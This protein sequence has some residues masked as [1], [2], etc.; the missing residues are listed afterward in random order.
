[1]SFIGNM[2]DPSKSTGFQAQSAPVMNLTDPSQIAAANAGVG[3]AA[4]SQKA[5]ADAAAGAGG[6]ANQSSVYN[7]QAALGNQLGGLNGAGTEG[8]AT[9]QGQQ[10]GN[11]LLGAGGVQAQTAALGQNAALTGQ[12]GGANGV[13]TQSSAI[14]GLQNLAGQQ[15]GLASQ[16][17]NIANGTG[18][19]PAQAMLNN[20]TGQNVANQAA[21]MASQRGAGSNVGLLARQAGQQGANTQQQAVGQGA[22][23]QA[24]QSLG[25]LSGLAAQQQAIGNTQSQIGGLGTTQVGQ[26]LSAIGQGAGIGAGLTGQ[27]QTQVANNYGMGSNTVGQQMGQQQ[28]LGNTAQNQVAN[29]QAAL[30]GAANTAL[31]NQSA[32]L[33]AGQATNTANVANTSN[34][35]TTNAGVANT[36]IGAGSGAIGGLLKGGA[37]ALGLAGAAEGGTVSKQG[38]QKP[39]YAQGDVV[40]YGGTPSPIVTPTPPA[41]VQPQGSRASRFLA[42]VGTGIE[43]SGGNSPAFQ[44]GTQIG[45]GLGQL[46]GMAAKGIKSQFGGITS[47]GPSE[48]GDIAQTSDGTLMSAHG[49]KVPALVSPGERYLPPKEVKK[50]VEGK[51]DPMSA[52]EKIPGKAKV[53]GAKNSYAN[54]T[55]PK[56]LDEGGIVLPRSVTQHKNPHWAAHK[57]VSDLMAQGK[58]RKGLK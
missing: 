47:G 58:L 42:G 33:Q 49:G 57:F 14:Q 28:A 18:P 15:Q 36:N 44:G 19:N 7:S 11:S 27:A 32:Q 46:G 9:A 35:N 41:P 39:M 20:A 8:T 26:Q 25:A 48:A 6:V 21:L 2:L 13:G 37:S 4:A 29:T 1:M 40:Q 12:L 55:V 17:Q 30:T 43:S 24:N 50:V 3:S 54:D 16:Y 22:T 23:M 56:T 5:F 53:K 10:L 38:M 34:Q 45:E 31:G 52:G 51:K